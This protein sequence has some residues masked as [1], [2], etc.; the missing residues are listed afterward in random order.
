MA[1]NQSLVKKNQRGTD[2]VY[3]VQPDLIRQF[4]EQIYGFVQFAV[5]FI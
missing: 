3:G 5:V 4:R 1:S 2:A